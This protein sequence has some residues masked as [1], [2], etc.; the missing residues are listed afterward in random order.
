[1]GVLQDHFRA[2]FA[3]LKGPGPDVALMAGVLLGRGIAPTS[4]TALTTSPG[5]VPDAIA[6]AAP[7]RAAILDAMAQA[8]AASGPGDT[9]LF[10][11]SG[12]GSQAPDQDG[13]EPGGP[14]DHR[15]TLDRCCH[16]D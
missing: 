5:M 15:R 2:G 8:G 7:T 10:Y 3:D 14:C 13:D 4:I 1:M 12:H 11:F 6:T 16:H 9:V